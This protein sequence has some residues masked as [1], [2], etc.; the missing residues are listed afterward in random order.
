MS[1]NAA[2]R[3]LNPILVLLAVSQA[4]SALLADH[5][6][7]ATF[8]WL[9]KGGG[10]LLLVAIALHVVLNWPWFRANLLR[11]KHA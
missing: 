11:R 5:L 7:R 1:K 8:Q 10:A 9:H 2:F 3:I 6:P 4:V